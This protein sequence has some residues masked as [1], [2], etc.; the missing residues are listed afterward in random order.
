VQAEDYNF[1]LMETQKYFHQEVEIQLSIFRPERGKFENQD[2]FKN[3][4]FWLEKGINIQSSQRKNA[5]ANNVALDY[6]L[7]GVKID[8]CHLGCTYNVGCCHYFNGKFVNARK[9]FSL[10][11]KVNSEHLDS[12]FGLAASCLKLGLD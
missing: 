4:E 3:A 9:W 2:I 10:A 8:P 1:E 5:D 11:I 6:Y 12:Y 7:S